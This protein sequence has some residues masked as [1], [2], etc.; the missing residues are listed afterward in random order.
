MLLLKMEF[1][2]ELLLLLRLPSEQSLLLLQNILEERCGECSEECPASVLPCNSPLPPPCPCLSLCPCPC[3]S[4][5]AFSEVAL[6]QGKKCDV[7]APP[8]SSPFPSITP[9][10]LD[11]LPALGVL[12][13]SSSQQS[14]S[15]FPYE[16]LMIF[17]PA[18]IHSFIG[19]HRWVIVYVYVFCLHD[20]ISNIS[21]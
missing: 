11:V 3:T 10:A 4:V 7:F 2:L 13:N 12:I 16:K 5:L 9:S 15:S 1:E 8:L 14:S 19:P 18:I 17:L 6:T 21:K 20:I